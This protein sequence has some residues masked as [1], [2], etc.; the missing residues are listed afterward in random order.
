MLLKEN[1]QIIMKVLEK[2]MGRGQNG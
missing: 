1:I 2:F